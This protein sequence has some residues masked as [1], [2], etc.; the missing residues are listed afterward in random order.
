[1]PDKNE[2]NKEEAGLVAPRRDYQ[3][4]LVT[5]RRDAKVQKETPP[6]EPT[7]IKPKK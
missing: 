5:P 2:I 4:G 3:V 1:M 7:E 6:K